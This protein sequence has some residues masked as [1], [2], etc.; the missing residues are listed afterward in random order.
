MRAGIRTVEVRETAFSPVISATGKTTF[1]PQRMAAVGAS[2]LG[3]V[4]RVAKYEET[5]SAR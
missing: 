2:A 5:W 4:R 1:D 3:T